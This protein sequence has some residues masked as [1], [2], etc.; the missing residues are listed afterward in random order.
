M[1]VSQLEVASETWDYLTSIPSTERTNIENV[2]V[3]HGSAHMFVLTQFSP[4]REIRIHSVFHIGVCVS[5]S[6]Y[7][8]NVGICLALP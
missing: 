6:E 2:S 4:Y 7:D 8:I 1:A 5:I 3:A